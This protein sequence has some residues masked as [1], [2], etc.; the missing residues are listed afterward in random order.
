[1]KQLLVCIMVFTAAFVAAKDQ[2]P[3]K[4]IGKWLGNCDTCIYTVDYYA[5]TEK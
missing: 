2:K 5:I 1:M 4:S 3:P